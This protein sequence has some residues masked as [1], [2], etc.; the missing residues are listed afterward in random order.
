MKR[1]IS[2]LI[3]EEC[4]LC[5][6]Y[7]VTDSPQFQ[8]SPLTIDI[9]FVKKGIADHFACVQTRDIRFY[10]VGESTTHFELVKEIVAYARSISSSRVNVELQT[11]GYFSVEIAEWISRNVDSVWISLDGPPEIN[12]RYRKTLEGTGSSE[13][14]A[15]NIKYLADKI[16]VGIRST[17]TS[18]NIARQKELLDYCRSLG[19]MKVAT[20]PVLLPVGTVTDNWSVD[21]LE[22]AEYF[23]EAWQYAQKRG[24]FYTCVLIFNF[25]RPVKY[26][27]RSCFPTP[28][29]TPDGYVSACDRAFSGETP[30]K[31]LIYGKWLPEE[32]KIEYDQARMNEI[33]QRS[34]E[35]MAHCLSCTAR[36][37][38]A[39]NCMGTGYQETGDL[40][41]VSERYCEAIRYLFEKMRPHET[42]ISCQGDHP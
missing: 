22:Y 6:E 20:K 30:L 41:G 18:I 17:C 7:C 3:T 39:G 32:R 38:C 1:P 13:V 24:M 19:V 33:R 9:D 11:N 2:V 25:D 16:A 34:P 37:Y 27:C 10:S 14:V 40:L 36:D 42:A 31:D 15:G 35:F 12:D 8:K 28:H 21:L 4:N 23:L 5:C 29:L 26:A